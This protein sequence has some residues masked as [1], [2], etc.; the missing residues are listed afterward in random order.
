MRRRVASL[1]VRVT[2]IIV[3]VPILVGDELPQ[4]RHQILDQRALELVDE[5]RARRVQ[6]VHEQESL[7]DVS[8]PHDVAGLLGQVHDLHVFLTTYG[9]RPPKHL[10]WGHGYIG[11]GLP[12]GLWP[13]AITHHDTPSSGA[14][15]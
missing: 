2:G 12:G 1:A 8:L 10:D 9:H 13:Y 11:N 5:E 4:H 14:P 15:K 7:L 6:R 3:S